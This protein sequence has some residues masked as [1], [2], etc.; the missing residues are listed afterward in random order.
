MTA[1][2]LKVGHVLGRLNTIH[3]FHLWLR[4]SLRMEVDEGKV[5]QKREEELHEIKRM[6]VKQ[7]G[8][9]PPAVFT[10]GDLKPKPVQHSCRRK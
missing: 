8:T 9:W 2:S 6:A 5:R 7:D 4:D 10:H 1:A 3:G